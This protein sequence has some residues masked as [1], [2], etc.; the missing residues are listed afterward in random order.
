MTKASCLCLFF[1]T[2]IAP[3]FCWLPLTLCSNEPLQHYTHMHTN[4]SNTHIHMNAWHA[5]T[6]AHTYTHTHTSMPH[7]HAKTHMCT[8]TIPPT[9]IHTW[10]RL[11]YANLSHPFTCTGNMQGFVKSSNAYIDIEQKE[12]HLDSK[13]TEASWSIKL[14]DWHQSL[15]LDIEQSIH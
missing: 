12:K 10:P 15:H 5:H 4:T 14:A 2:S 3:K 11:D 7:W 1:A 9:P 13:D 6:H 8:C